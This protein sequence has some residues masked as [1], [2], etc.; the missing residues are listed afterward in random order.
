[1]IVQRIK[2]LCRDRGISMRKLERETGIGNGVIARWE[3]SN[4]TVENLGKVADYFNVT[5]D[6]LRK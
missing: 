4:P 3:K 6:E 5:I 1:M 2:S